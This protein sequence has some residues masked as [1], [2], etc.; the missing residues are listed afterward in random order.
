M[1]WISKYSIQYW[2]SNFSKIRGLSRESLREI[3]KY[4]RINEYEKVR[5]QVVNIRSD[6]VNRK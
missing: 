1:I 6:K 3:R 5:V 4:M 2:N